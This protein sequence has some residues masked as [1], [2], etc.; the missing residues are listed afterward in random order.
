MHAPAHVGLTMRIKD[1]QGGTAQ[2]A[3]A[4]SHLQIDGIYLSAS[5]EVQ[6]QTLSHFQLRVTVEAISN[7]R[8]T[9]LH[10]QDTP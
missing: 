6:K 5:E 7:K 1:Q 4:V 2:A 9:W 8:K 10:G 3:E